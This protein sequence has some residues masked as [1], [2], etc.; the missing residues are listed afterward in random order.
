MDPRQPQNGASRSAH[1]FELD[2]AT[3]ASFQHADQT[4]AFR[5]H[6]GQAA[7]ILDP[8]ISDHQISTTDPVQGRAP[9]QN[10]DQTSRDRIHAPSITEPA[11]GNNHH[12]SQVDPTEQREPAQSLHQPS[13]GPM[14]APSM[15]VPGT[16][17]DYQGPP[18]PAQGRALARSPRQTS[19]CPMGAPELFILGPS[20]GLESSEI[21]ATQM[22]YI[23]EPVMPARPSG[24]YQSQRI[25]PGLDVPRQ[26]AYQAQDLP[27]LARSGCGIS[28]AGTRAGPPVQQSFASCPEQGTHTQ[29]QQYN[30]RDTPS[31]YLAGNAADN[32]LDLDAED[33]EVGSHVHPAPHHRSSSVMTNPYV[34]RPD[35]AF[36]DYNA[37]SYSSTQRNT[38]RTNTPYLQQARG[39]VPSSSNGR[40]NLPSYNLPAS[41]RREHKGMGHENRRKRSRSLFEGDG[42]NTSVAGGLLHPPTSVGNSHLNDHN[43]EGAGSYRGDDVDDDEDAEEEEYGDLGVR[44]APLKRR[45]LGNGGIA[46]DR[47]TY[48]VNDLGGP[49]RPSDPIDVAND[50]YPA[51]FPIDDGLCPPRRTFAANDWDGIG[52]LDDPVAGFDPISHSTF[53]VGDLGTFPDAS[54]PAFTPTGASTGSRPTGRRARGN[55]G[56]LRRD[57]DGHVIFRAHGLQQWGNIGSAQAGSCGR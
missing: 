15:L 54:T 23:H 2:E 42:N 45:R 51:T 12:S 43:S 44:Q 18:M 11:T 9:V 40:L 6:D 56:V 24:S 36:R 25:A 48:P 32:P 53:P 22:N 46:Q 29:T 4:S 41:A 57:R 38:P 35:P 3:R 5:Y 20:N 52:N 49:A 39:Q 31:P 27:S 30:R 10:P 28:T 7:P 13:T 19:T 21:N 26:Q 47:P 1:G 55:H 16:G 33:H 34:H 50:T 14:T 37:P 17:N 8:R